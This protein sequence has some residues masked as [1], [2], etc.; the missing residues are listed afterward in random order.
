LVALSTPTESLG[1]LLDVL[2]AVELVVAHPA[3]T[4]AATATTAPNIN[5][6]A[7]RRLN[8]STASLE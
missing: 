3:I 2:P 4:V 8:I 5:V 1:L 7:A 6:R